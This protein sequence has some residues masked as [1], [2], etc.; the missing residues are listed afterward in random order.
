[1]DLVSIDAQ[2][3]FK[4]DLDHL[5]LDPGL[6]WMFVKSEQTHILRDGHCVVTIPGHS[7]W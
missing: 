5:I 7:V 2:M 4:H 1:M 3:M 6:P